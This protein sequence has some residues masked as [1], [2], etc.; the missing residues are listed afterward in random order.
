MHRYKSLS[1]MLAAVADQA[2]KHAGY[3]FVDTGESPLVPFCVLA[4]E[5]RQAAAWLQKQGLR[6]GERVI[7][8]LPTSRDFAAAF[9]GAVLCGAVPCVLPP[10][11][12]GVATDGVERIQKVAE[13]IGAQRLI[14]R[15]ENLTAWLPSLPTV[16]GHAVEGLA[17]GD[18]KEW[19]PVTVLASDLAYIQATSGS[20]GTP[21]CVALTHSNLLSNLEQ[22]GRALRFTERDVLV[23]WLPLFHDMGLI[24]CFLLTA[25]WQFTGVLMSPYRFLRNPLSFLKAIS[26]HG[27]TASGNPTFAYALMTKRVRDEDLAG[28]NLSTWNKALCG[29]EPVSQETLEGFSEKFRSCGF[30]PHSFVPCYGLAEAS[31][32]VT[33]HA[34]GE[35]LSSEWID[36]TALANGFAEPQATADERKG[37]RITNCGAPVEGSGVEVRTETG[38]L[39]PEGAIG[40]IWVAGP[41]VMQG[42]C[43]AESPS[44]SILRDGWLNTG[45]LGYLRNGK[46]FVTGRHKDLI[47]IRGQKWRPTDFELAAAE[48]SL[49]RVVAFGVEQAETG[50]EGLC[51]LCEEPR[52]SDPERKEL[53]DRVHRHVTTKTGVI[54][55]YVRFVPRNSLP[56]TTSGK[57]QRSQAKQMFLTEML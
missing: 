10:P 56:H 1:E 30:P 28:L 14:A 48:V 5:A 6:K 29:S 49:G 15:G 8:I 7:V 11:T 23:G 24:G 4:L 54:P 55:T 19:K 22:I 40:H 51:V 2:G 42:Y 17:S 35:P 25:Y 31:L 32:A 43:P 57:P 21:K 45:D 34:L 46:L 39:Q 41:S 44:A 26:T 50:T 47:I 12:L 38:A 27:G 33:M 16:Q 37:L 53:L 3:R 18:E 36:R 13:R 20:T 52:S 9:Y